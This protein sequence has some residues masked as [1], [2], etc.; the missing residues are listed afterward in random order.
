MLNNKPPKIVIKGVVHTLGP[1]HKVV[2]AGNPNTYGGERE[3]PK[4]FEDY[5]IARV[6]FK[7]IPHEYI[8]ESILKPRL[9]HLPD[10]Q[11]ISQIFMGIYNESVMTVRDV[12]HMAHL[13]LVYQKPDSNPEILAKQCADLILHQSSP[14]LSFP[15]KNPMKNHVITESRRPLESRLNEFLAI[16]ELKIKRQ[17]KGGLGGIIIEGDPGTGKSEHVIAQL[18]ANNLQGSF[19]H[20][21]ISMA[22]SEKKELLIKAFNEGAIVIIDE[23][24]SSP[25]MEKFFNDALSGKLEGMESPRP[26]FLLI[27]TQNP[28]SMGARRELSE[29]MQRRLMHIAVD[30]FPHDEMVE[31]LEKGHNIAKPVAE[32]IVKDLEAVNRDRARPLSMRS[33]IKNHQQAIVHI[34]NTLLQR[35]ESMDTAQTIALTGALIKILQASSAASSS[36]ASQSPVLHR[37][38]QS[39]PSSQTTQPAPPKPF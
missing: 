32:E 30:H 31:V 27:G 25:A 12:E 38:T 26:G 22:F 29:A 2:F 11:Y 10:W 23:I 16:R 1:G 5:P 8:I 28:A 20:I 39:E 19:Y 34:Q 15:C 3:S 14:E 21:P 33:L 35:L 7:N 9:Q 24:N 17:I 4:L 13:Y 37:F 36:S 6:T 18:L